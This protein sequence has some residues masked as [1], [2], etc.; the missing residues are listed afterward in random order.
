MSEHAG[1]F[2]LRLIFVFVTFSA[3]KTAVCRRQGSLRGILKQ[4]DIANVMM[5][6]AGF[7]KDGEER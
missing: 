1:P 6:L 7:G 2:A 3:V 5:A 4:S